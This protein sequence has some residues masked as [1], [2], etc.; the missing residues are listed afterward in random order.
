MTDA[1]AGTLKREM[2]V[3]GV[4][5]GGHFM[6]HCYSMMLPPL[7]PILHL[8]LG[9]SYTALGLML[10]LRSL[11]F[12]SMQLPAGILVDRFGARLI[13][14]LGFAIILTCYSLMAMSEA[15]W[16]VA[17]FF[18]MSGLGDAAIHP[19]D[20]AIMNG[21]V[22]SSRM[23]RSFSAHIF[24]GSLGMAVAPAA[25]L[26]MIGSFGWTWRQVMFAFVLIGAVVIAG[27]LTQWRHI[28]VAAPKRREKPR[29]EAGGQTASSEE[30]VWQSLKAVLSS[31]PMLFLLLFFSF[32]ALGTGAFKNF[33]VAGLVSLHGTSLE[34][35]GG[36]LTGFLTATAFGALIGGFVADRFGRHATAAVIALLLCAGIAV[37]VGSVNLHYMV[38]TFAFTMAGLLQGIIRP[39]RDMMIRAASPKGSIG[40]AFGFVSSGHAVGG[41]IA[42]VLLGALLDMGLPEWLFY[43][44]A[45]FLFI[46]LLT[47][48]GSAYW[49]KKERLAA[50]E[51][52]AE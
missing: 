47:V 5:S 22:A 11:L 1:A 25:V 26:I 35:A 39:A 6:S 52:A 20:Y 10:S 45:I 33:A 49:S 7:F 31:M 15:F 4:V 9:V 2:K 40:K 48:L 18:I 8:E 13:L 23:G 16:M 46:C 34:A 19:A 51:T 14:V 21:I 24:G 32:S 42:P 38:L 36:A 50:A 27:L 44:S 29:E 41:T 3:V 30:T 28:Q 43:C 12:G 37:L 17:A